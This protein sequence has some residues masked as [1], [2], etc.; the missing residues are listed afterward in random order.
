M[1]GRSRRKLAVRAGRGM[2]TAAPFLPGPWVWRFS[3]TT[4]SDGGKGRLSGPWRETTEPID[5]PRAALVVPERPT[6][7]VVLAA[8]AAVRRGNIAARTG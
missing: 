6:T 3:A 7:P 1:S 5:A 4:V 2:F 8:L